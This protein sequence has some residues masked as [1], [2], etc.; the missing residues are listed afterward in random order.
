[1]HRTLLSCT[2]LLVLFTL[3]AYGAGYDFV[4]RVCHSSPV[5]V[6]SAVKGGGGF[7]LPVNAHGDVMVM[8]VKEA[9]RVL[10]TGE[11]QSGK[12]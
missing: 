6:Y 3:E 5:F 2:G 12:S 11:A 1:M 7:E 8:D 4:L 10:L 9:G